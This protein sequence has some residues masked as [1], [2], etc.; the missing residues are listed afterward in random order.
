M[1]FDRG[2]KTFS[3]ELF[4]SSDSAAASGR[5][6]MVR[7]A[8]TRRVSLVRGMVT[9]HIAE[10]FRPGVSWC[11][12]GLDCGVSPSPALPAEGRELGKFARVV[13]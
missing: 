10:P 8:M 7:S 4:A 5:E 9:L 1:R 12:V 3:S 13:F 11:E 6:A 2:R